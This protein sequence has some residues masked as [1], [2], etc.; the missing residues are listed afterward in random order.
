[1]LG[2]PRTAVSIVFGITDEIVGKPDNK[3]CDHVLSRLWGELYKS[4]VPELRNNRRR[5][6]YEVQNSALS[7]VVNST[8]QIEGNV[9]NV[10]GNLRVRNERKSFAMRRDLSVQRLWRAFSLCGKN[11]AWKQETML[12]S[13]IYY[14]F[15]GGK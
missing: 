1:M 4:S 13:R 15:Q 8:L 12:C 11:E 14:R 5:L 10:D 3:T 6:P 7:Q 2:A 9:N